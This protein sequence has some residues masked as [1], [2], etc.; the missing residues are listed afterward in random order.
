MESRTGIVVALMLALGG[1]GGDGA[2]SLFGTP[3]DSGAGGEDP[4]SGGSQNGGSAGATSAGRSGS[5]AGGSAGSTGSGGKGGSGKGGSA[6]AASGGSPQGG[7]GEGSGGTESGGTES[8]GS[9]GSSA[10]SD[11]AGGRGGNGGRGG[12]GGSAGKG[13]TDCDAIAADYLEALEGAQDCNPDIDAVQCTEQ[14]PSNLGCGCPTFVNPA[15]QEEMDRLKELQAAWLKGCPIAV[16]PALACVL[17]ERGFCTSS[18]SG[19]AHCSEAIA[20]K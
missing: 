20:A 16:C 8:G 14:V 5:S 19:S 17:P 13:E 9:S 3:S 11:P 2:E 4:G 7:A 6:G 15:N 10:G 12:K 18:G 1:C